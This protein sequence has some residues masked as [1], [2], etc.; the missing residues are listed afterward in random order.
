MLPAVKK[1]QWM[2]LASVLLIWLVF[3]VGFILLP[4]AEA[5]AAGHGITISGSGLN[6]TEPVNI[7]QEQLCGQEPLP[8][9][10]QNIYGQEYLEQHDEWYSTI[11]TWPTKNWY[12]GKGVRLSELLK[13][14]GGLNDQARHIRFTSTDGFTTAYSIHTILEAPRYRFPNFRD[15]GP[16]GHLIGDA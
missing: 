16:Y 8:I 6:V 2:R 7:T 13:T 4:E 15:T 12:R 3:T 11:N 5:Y 1:K 10:L 9:E 14:A